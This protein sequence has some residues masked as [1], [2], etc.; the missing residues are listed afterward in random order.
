MHTKKICI[1]FFLLLS[2]NVFAEDFSIFGSRSVFSLSPAADISLSGTAVSMY[3]S[4][5]IC[6]KLLNI[7]PA[8]APDSSKTL[9]S[10]ILIDSIF[11]RPY[12]KTQDKISDI[13]AAG[14]ILSPAFL[15]ITPA[16]EWF[17]IGTMYAETALM[18]YSLKCIGKYFISRQ[19]PYMYFPG[20]PEDAVSSG[21]W[22]DSFPSAHATMS[23]ATATF[24]TYVFAK[25]FPDSNWK[26]GVAAIS[27][28]AAIAISTLRITAGCHFL[29]DVI[30]GAAIGSLC[31]FLVPWIHT[32]NINNDKYNASISPLSVSFSI[33]L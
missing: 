23:F 7:N 4:Y 15:M 27:Y 3:G 28:S 25:Y 22:C 10:V 26:Y 12:S 16:E 32:F 2:F 6:D 29:T 5:L 31:G 20:A 24:S 33:K 13:L 14:L 18:A 1:T 17:T 21:D 19:R 9:D 11:A 8:P 30:A